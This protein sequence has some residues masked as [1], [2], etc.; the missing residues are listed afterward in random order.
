[1]VPV[2]AG[3]SSIRGTYA[4]R[5]IKGLVIRRTNANPAI[6]Q[7]AGNCSSPVVIRKPSH[8]LDLHLAGKHHPVL[9]EIVP[10]MK[11]SGLQLFAARKDGIFYRHLSRWFHERHGD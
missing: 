11:I 1:M 5:V 8:S 6:Y 10:Q 4:D 2:F 9:T 3:I 7:A